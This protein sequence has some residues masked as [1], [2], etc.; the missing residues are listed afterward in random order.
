MPRWRRITI[1]A[2]GSTASSITKIFC[3]KL[4]IYLDEQVE[5]YLAAKAEIKGIDLSDLVTDLLKTKNR[6]YRNSEVVFEIW[7]AKREMVC[8]NRDVKTWRLR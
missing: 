7:S 6:D 8:Q 3:F 4:P 5:A 1:S 2:K